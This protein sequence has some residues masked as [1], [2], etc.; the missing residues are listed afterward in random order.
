M[1]AEVPTSALS[2]VWRGRLLT[3]S[4]IL[5]V[6][7]IGFYSTLFDMVR[8][9]STSSTFNHGFLIAPIAIYIGWQSR[10]ELLATVP[11]TAFS[12]VLFAFANS[13]LWVAGELASIAFFQ[14][15][16]FVGL[17]IG[18]SWA[19]LGA[20]AFR[21]LLFP[22]FYL[23]FAVPEGEFLVPYLQ[24]WTALVLVQMLRITGIPVFLEGRYLAIPSGNFVVAEACSGINYLIA[25][26]AV[27]TMFMYLNFKSLGRR[28]AF[29]GIV[30][31]V[32]LIANGLRAYG[33]VMIA[34]LS[35]YR[36]AMGID[37]FVYG[38]VFFGIVIFAVF[39]I[40]TLFSDVGRQTSPRPVATN[41]TDVARGAT[42]P[43]IVL[44]LLAG[45]FG[46]RLLLA[47]NDAGRPLAAPIALP[48]IAGWVG[49]EPVE[50]RLGAEFDGADDYLA[51]LYRNE[52]GRT[53]VLELVYFQGERDDTELVSQVNSLF[54]KKQWKQIAYR[55]RRAPKDG[56]ATDVYEMEL[57]ATDT[58]TDYLVWQWYD[59][60]GRRSARRLP[61]K[62][63]Q[64]AA[65]LAGDHL[66]GM[67]V[68]V[69]TK[70]DDAPAARA[71][72]AAFSS[73][74]SLRLEF[75]LDAD[76]GEAR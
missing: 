52:E 55:Q 73:A 35:D 53:V 28:A 5:L 2:A 48:S 45:V 41:S 68:S 69:R 71:A 56:I 29:M 12:G 40:G 63:A 21:V 26:L 10:I 47:L 59:A 16:S 37:H 60:A 11:G 62:L 6:V 33:I 72:L 17:L 67:S 64:A 54:N 61:I 18:T 43:V 39:A 44:L 75:L 19:I 22:L 24:D 1:I 70:F 49:P 27:G 3:I 74:A 8:I 65:R 14:H 38:W 46:P 58:E 23:Y 31:L 42:L 50:Q 15:A 9:W 76:P 7:V 34:H 20:G 4:A 51:G 36:H 13:L 25:T 66:G 30:V 32:P 57:R